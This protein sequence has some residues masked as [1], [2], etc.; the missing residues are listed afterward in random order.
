MA[1][2]PSTSV[3]SVEQCS[4]GEAERHGD[5]VEV[6][7]RRRELA[8]LPSSNEDDQVGVVGGDGGGR[9]RFGRWVDDCRAPVRITTAAAAL[10]CS[11]Y[12]L[13]SWRVG[14]SSRKHQVPWTT[15][16]TV[17]VEEGWQTAVELAGLDGLVR[18]RLVSGLGSDT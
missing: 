10:D 7:G 13:D 16:W 18:Q 6:E 3:L 1:A 11:W 14:Q 15:N 4:N 5:G 2:P 8:K 9:W 12:W 17:L